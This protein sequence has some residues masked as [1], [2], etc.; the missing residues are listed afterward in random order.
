[1]TE[2]SKKMTAYF[3]AVI[4][5]IITSLPKVGLDDASRQQILELTMTYLG[6]QGLVDVALSIKGSKTK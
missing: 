4:V 3:A 2:F 1:M 5:L 6:A